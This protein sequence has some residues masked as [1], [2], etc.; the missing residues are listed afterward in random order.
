MKVGG[1]R[2][3]FIPTLIT[4]PT[5]CYIPD[6]GEAIPEHSITLTPKGRLHFN[7]HQKYGPSKDFFNSEEIILALGGESDC[8][9]VP[10]LK[11]Y[12]K[13][14]TGPRSIS[15]ALHSC[16]TL[17]SLAIQNNLIHNIRNSYRLKQEFSYCDLRSSFKNIIYETPKITLCGKR[18]LDSL[19]LRLDQR[20]SFLTRIIRKQLKRLFPKDYD[21]FLDKAY[22]IIKP[23]EPFALSR[24]NLPH[25]AFTYDTLL[26][27]PCHNPEFCSLA[28]MSNNWYRDFYHTKFLRLGGGLTLYHVIDDSSPIR[29]YF[30]APRNTGHLVQL[31]IHRNL[32]D[33][34]NDIDRER[35]SY[36]KQIPWL[37]KTSMYNSN[38]A[39]PRSYRYRAIHPTETTLHKP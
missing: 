37:H 35:F 1:K 20:P 2:V 12:R 15:S 24:E 19:N 23:S 3:R 21:G 16:K 29:N 32:H 36:K 25:E 22:V 8:N 30:E 18:N 4:I 13:N 38:P 33:F 7:T 10:V 27:I 14:I 5:G 39:K 26:V 31:R 11:N 9:C 34:I 6:I 28:D 17:E